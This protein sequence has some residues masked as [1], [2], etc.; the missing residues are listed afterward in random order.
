MRRGVAVLAEVTAKTIKPAEMEEPEDLTE[1]PGALAHKAAARGA[2]E[3]LD[4]FMGVR[5]AQTLVEG[6]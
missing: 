6:R 3:Q 2:T 4:S 5:G 1:L